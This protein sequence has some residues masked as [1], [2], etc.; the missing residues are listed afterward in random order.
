VATPD[1]SAPLEGAITINGHEIG[2]FELRLPVTLHHLTG[3]EIS[4]QVA[5]LS[6]AIAAT[7]RDMAAA[8][9]PQPEPRTV[10]A[11]VETATLTEGLHGDAVRHRYTA[12]CAD[13]GVVGGVSLVRELADRWARTHDRDEHPEG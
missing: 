10:H 4:V 7:L 9:D 2:T 8:L 3:G 6:P 5:P 1:L 13:C 11:T 12:H